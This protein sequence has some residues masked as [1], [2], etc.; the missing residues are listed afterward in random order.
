M[1]NQPLVSIILPVYNAAPFLRQSLES[2]IDQTYRKFELIIINDGSSDQSDDII[3]SYNDPRIRYFKH[4]NIG[5]A[6]TL[7]KAIQLVNGDYIWRHDADDISLNDK[8]ESQVQ[9][10][11]ANPEFA[12]CATQIAFMTERGR[13]AWKFRQPND[14]F[15]CGNN[16]IE[17]KREHFNPFSPITHATVL[18][19][20]DVMREL[21]GYRTAFRTGEDVDLWLRLIQSY[22]AAVIN[23]C[24]YFVRINNASATKRA[25]NNNQYF[26]NLAFSFYE[27]RLKDGKDELQKNLDFPMNAPLPSE[28]I[29]I[30]GH[31]KILR[32]D[33]LSY[34][35]PLHINAR[36]WKASF[37][38][39]KLA[40][41]DGWRLKETYK[42]LLFT[43]I[44]SD[45]TKKMA[46]LKKKL[47]S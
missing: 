33:L 12:L 5:V 44:G 3:T 31:G 17:V 43:L 37:K 18:I 30:N 39:M 36:D 22:R 38:L 28:P 2:I 6:A 45:N 20:T 4:A 11:M 23:R 13:I 10:M 40:L 9:F 35:Y 15:F 1:E 32:S 47:K 26:R 41:K 16:H 25:G 29:K 42:S 34:H 46:G 21:K 27:Q 14:N 8:L 19:K 24:D 7:N